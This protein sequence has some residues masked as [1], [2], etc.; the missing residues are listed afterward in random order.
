MNSL[1]LTLI[2]RI[3]VCQNASW[4]QLLTESLDIDWGSFWQFGNAYIKKILEL[5]K[6]KFWSDVFNSLYTFKTLVD[7]DNLLFQP[8]WYNE[9]FLIENKTLFN[10]L[11]YEKGIRYVY[12][13]ID[14]NCELL[15]FNAFQIKY[16]LNIPFTIYY[17][18]ITCISK[19]RV[20]LS[21]FKDYAISIPFIPSSIKKI[22][23]E[24][25]GTKS[26]YEIFVKRMYVKPKSELKW[27]YDLNIQNDI[28]WWENCNSIL[29]YLTKDVKL[30]WFNY[31]ILHRIIST[32]AYLYKIGIKE[33]DKCSFCGLETENISHLFYECSYVRS[34][35]GQI[36]SWI[37]EKLNIDKDFTIENILFG[38]FLH[39]KILTLIITLAK[40]HIYRQKMRNALPST[41]GFKQELIQYRKYEKYIY[42]KKFSINKYINKWGIFRFLD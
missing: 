14:V 9:M 4:F 3:L 6:N 21:E 34:F 31:R 42:M 38:M 41:Y 26:L 1:K 19:R 24:K 40:Y 32:N 33:S 23:K 16:S 25:K 39:M 15:S 37:K 5:N 11:M 18:I 28:A 13:L 8:L 30:L 22:T 36:S 35:W 29:H 7:E 10:K 2:R 12:D 20:N 27:E 17:G